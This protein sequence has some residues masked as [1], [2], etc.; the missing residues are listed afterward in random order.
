MDASTLSIE[1]QPFVDA[2][3]RHLKAARQLRLQANSDPAAA[4]DRLCLRDWQAGRLARTH[5]DLLASPRFGA[6]AKFFLTDLYGPKDFSSRDE[7]VER[8]LPL[9]TRML[10]ASALHTVA[11]AVE[12]DAL[13]EA[14][15]SAV[16]QLDLAVAARG[17]A[18]VVR[19]DQ[20]G[21]AVV[22]VALRASGRTP[23]RP[24]TRVEVAGGFVGQHQPAASSDQRAGDR[25]ALLHAARELAGALGF[26]FQAHA[27]STRAPGLGL[28]RG[29]AVRAS[30]PAGSRSPAR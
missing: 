13:S 7:E 16:H 8:I 12:L 28:G 9:L 11:L 19:D 20:A 21:A 4:R 2:L 26:A 18:R 3:R 22:A 6:A 5:A 29:R 14:L 25:H 17:Q 27:A 15:D 1:K 30:W 10:P 24:R 23:R